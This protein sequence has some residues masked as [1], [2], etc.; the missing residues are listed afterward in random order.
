M[1]S[2][3]VGGVAAAV[4]LLTL[5]DKREAFALN[6]AA[7]WS[8]DLASGRVVSDTGAP[9]LALH[10]PFT[11]RVRIEAVTLHAAP[12]APPPTRLRLFTNRS[13]FAFDDMEGPPVASFAVSSLPATFRLNAAKF[14]ACSSLTV[15]IDAGG[16]AET[17]GIGR[18]CVSGTTLLS[19]NVSKIS[20]GH[21]E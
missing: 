13:A 7:P 5:L 20:K 1:S 10:L 3:A 12:G 17:V 8:A 21:E 16:D 11:E 15:C 6:T 4:E 2:P 14:S 18:L 9:A 19:A